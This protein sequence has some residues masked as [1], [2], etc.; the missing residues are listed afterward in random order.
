MSFVETD[1]PAGDRILPRHFFEARVKIELA[2]KPVAIN[3]EGWARDLSESGLGAFVGTKL[4]IGE[5]AILK[6][7]LPQEVEVTIPAVVARN[8]GTQYGFRFTALS[9]QQRDELRRA[10]AVRKPVPYKGVDR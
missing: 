2:R 3:V 9:R 7:P 8:L 10:L 5:H 4:F 1:K 6:I